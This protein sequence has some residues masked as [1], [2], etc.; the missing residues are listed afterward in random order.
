MQRLAWFACALAL[1]AC[2]DDDDAIDGRSVVL[3]HGAW[4]GAWAWQDVAAGLEARGA[5]VTVVELPA[6]GEDQTPIAQVSLRAYIDTVEAAI[7]AAPGP[8]MLVGHSM[9]GVV[10]TEAADERAAKLDRLV[11][12]TAFVPKAGES[13]L[14]LR[15]QD[16]DS[17]LGAALTIEM[18]Q[19]IA[20]V[21]SDRLTPVFCADCATTANT[22]LHAAY[23][24]EP[25]GP[26]AEPAKLDDGGWV[27]VPKFYLYAAADHAISPANQQAMTA[28]ISWQATASLATSHSPFLSH[29]DDVVDVLVEFAAVR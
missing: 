12:V 10:V 22:K 8:V 17:E 20:G 18:A 19:G 2:A 28:G 4:N 3:V 1:G 25:L 23:R 7:D 27:G 26:F 11:Y 14:G 21:M 16:A 9:G 13:L 6:H 15:M 5:E 29:P 24:D